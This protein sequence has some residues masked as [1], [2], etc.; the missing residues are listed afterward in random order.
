[1]GDHRPLRDGN[2]VAD[3]GVRPPD[4]VADAGVRP[5]DRVADAGVRPPDPVNRRLRLQRHRLVRRV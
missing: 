1:M 3:A 4:P 5:P 2:P